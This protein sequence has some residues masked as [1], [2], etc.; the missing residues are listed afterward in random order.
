V[1][2][3]RERLLRRDR[4]RFVGRTA[5]LAA[6]DSMLAGDDPRRVMHV[7]GP[8]GIGKS[9]LLREVTRRAAQRGFDTVWIDG[10]DIPPFSAEIDAMVATLTETAPAIVVFDSYEL[11]NSLDSYLREAVIPE[12]PDSTLVVFASRLPVSKGWFEHGW[13]TVVDTLELRPLDADAARELVNVRGVSDP[14]DVA[15]LVRRSRGSPLALVVGAEAGPSGSVSELAARLLGDEVEPHRLRILSVAAIARVTTP[16]LID[17]VLGDDD[18]HESYK[19]LAD[20]SFSE[21]LATGVTLHALVADAVREQLRDRDPIGEGH[22]RRR[23]AD[24]LHRRAVAGNHGLSTDLQHLIV[25]PAV[26]WGYSSDIGQR[27]RID[28]LRPDDVDQVGSILEA[29]GFHDWWAVTRVFFD[30]HPELVGVA[31]DPEGRVGGYFV[32]VTPATRRPL[33]MPTCCSGRGSATPVTSCAPPVRCCGE[34]PST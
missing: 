15:E 10:R 34:R 29:V 6:F 32:A 28:S 22:L 17:E 8:G 24:H 11:I 13:D 33:R 1:T 2:T 20:R 26:R 14:L 3:I 4:D 9:A 19:W 27:F 5:E 7:V 18:P 30:E 31:R 23:I 25:D 12:L 21:P 16:E